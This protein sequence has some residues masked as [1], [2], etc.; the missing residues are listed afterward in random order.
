MLAHHLIGAVPEQLLG[1]AV[2]EGDEPFNVNGD[3]TLVSI[4]ED[5]RYFGGRLFQ[6]SI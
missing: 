6:R 2:E 3:D 1:G 4:I 5:G